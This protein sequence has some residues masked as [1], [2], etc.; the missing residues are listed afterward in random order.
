MNTSK[1][2]SSPSRSS[3][4]RSVALAQQQAQ[5][6]TRIIIGGAVAAAVVL[7]LVLA[8]VLGGGDDGS[9]APATTLAPNE[10]DEVIRLTTTVD[11]SALDTVG[12]GAATAG[13][14]KYAGTPITKDGLPELLYVGAEFC[15]FCAAERW[16]MVVALSRFGAF[17]NLSISR[18]ASEDVYP[19]TPTFTFYGSTYTSEYLAF[20][21]VE[22]ATNEPS[23]GGGYTRLQELT[24]AQ[25]AVIN[26]ANVGSSIPFLSF[27][28]QYVISGATYDVGVL[29]GLSAVQVARALGDVDSEIGRSVL[30]A[31]NGITAAICGITGNQ[32]A[33]VCESAGVQAAAKLI[34]A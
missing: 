19:N 15:P 28:G 20:T 24:P 5:R 8:L 30:G 32:P 27:G 16:A 14:V 13:P 26:E 12:N 18:S 11:A 9:S 4:K 6:R 17:E 23:S 31:A 1:K 22:T 10:T 21:P 29:E 7:A 33:A 3:Q 25:I 34:N 2:S